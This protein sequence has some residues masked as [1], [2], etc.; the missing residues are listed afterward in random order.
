MAEVSK[1]TVSWAISFLFGELKAI[2]P[3]T[4]RFILEVFHLIY[5]SIGLYDGSIYVQYR[6][7]SIQ[8][9]FVEY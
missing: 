5:K 6:D 2:G 3:V 7:K 1:K 8:I 4:Y 9:Q